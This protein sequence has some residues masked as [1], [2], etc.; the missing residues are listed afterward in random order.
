[1]LGAHLARIRPGDYFAVNAYVERSPEHHRELQALRHAVRDRRRVA[2]TLGYGPRFLHSTGQLHKG[3]PD[4]GIFLQITSDAADDL[5]I[6]GQR[7]GF[8]TLVQAQALGD[9]AVLAERRRRALR[10]HLGPE[11]AEGLARLRELVEL[12]MA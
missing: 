9:F 1:V 5:A 4:T 2:T 11:V 12:A 10:V 8:G 7:Y 3:G 6:P